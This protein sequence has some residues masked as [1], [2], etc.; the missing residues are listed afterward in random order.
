MTQERTLE[1]VDKLSAERVT[2]K[3]LALA[4]ELRRLLG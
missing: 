2:L 3:K 4:E 1:L